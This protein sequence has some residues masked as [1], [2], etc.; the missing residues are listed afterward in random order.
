MNICT[1]VTGS[2]TSATKAQKVLSSSAI[3]STIVKLDSSTTHR[4]CAYGIEIDCNQLSNARYILTN[5]NIK[6]VYVSKGVLL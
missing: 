4:G 1:I 3:K 5:S 6:A 2:I